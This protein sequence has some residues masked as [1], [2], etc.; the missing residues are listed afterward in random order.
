MPGTSSRGSFSQKLQASRMVEKQLHPFI[1]VRAANKIGQYTRAKSQR[2]RLG[3]NT[4]Q[5]YD[6]GRVAGSLGGAWKAPSAAQCWGAAHTLGGSA[7][8]ER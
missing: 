2:N 5:V 6:D 3:A 7:A 8:P 1:S 4:H